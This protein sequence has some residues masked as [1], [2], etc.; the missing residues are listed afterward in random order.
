MAGQI[1]CTQEILLTWEQDKRIPGI[2]NLR[3]I[4]QQIEIPQEYLKTALS[5]KYSIDKSLLF[6][7]KEIKQKLHNGTGCTGC[8]LRALRLSRLKTHREM[9][10]ELRIDPST[11]LDWENERHKPMSGMMERIRGLLI[12]MD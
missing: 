11:L 5:N 10:K 2:R 9:A 1:G 7:P 6:N 3:R 12:G 8:V 4:L